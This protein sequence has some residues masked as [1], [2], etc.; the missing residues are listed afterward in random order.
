LPESYYLNLSWLK[1]SPTRWL[2][3]CNVFK[4]KFLGSV[5]VLMFSEI[6]LFDWRI[7]SD[8]FALDSI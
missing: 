2:T 1:D 7:V 3:F 5:S 6:W 4:I 8:I